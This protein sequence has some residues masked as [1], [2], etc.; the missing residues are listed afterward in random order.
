MQLSERSPRLLGLVA[1]GLMAVATVVALTVQRADLGGGYALTAEFTDAGGL[2]AG[3]DVF[4]AGVRVGE[5][6]SLAIDGDHVVARMVIQGTELPATT[7]AAVKLRTLVGRRAV[8]LDTG[9]DFSQLLRDGDTIPRSRTSVAIDVPE[10]GDVSEE[11]LSEV[12][13]EALDTLLASLSDVTA[14]QREEVAL[15]VEGGTQ[16]AGVITEQEEELR[17]LLRAL[18]SVSETLADSDD[19]LVAVIDGFGTVLDSLAQRREDVRRLLRETNATSGTAADLV[20][21]TR[22]QLDRVLDELH[23]DLEIVNRHQVALAE[24]LAYAPEGVGGFA[25]ITRAGDVPTPYGKVFVTGLGAAGVDVL[26]GCGGAADQLFDELLGP[27][28][29]PCEEQTNRRFPRRDPGE[30]PTPLDQLA[31]PHA[32][33]A[34]APGGVAGPGAEQRLGLDAVARRLLPGGAGRAA[35]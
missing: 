15:L 12:D 1:V 23:A 19:D 13:S 8:E 35:P 7:R 32:D 2:R 27:D 25:E 28:P 16:L 18:R 33:G 17:R 22:G 3:D 31:P 34:P 24:A 14:D 4:V 9:D 20:A 21:D 5:V 29:R 10:F 6:T 30:Q 26:F 11:L